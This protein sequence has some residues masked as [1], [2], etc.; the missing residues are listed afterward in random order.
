MHEAGYKI[1]G[2]GEVGGG[3]VNKNGI[4]LK[5]LIEFRQKNGT[6]HG[7]PGAEKCRYRRICSPPSA[8][9]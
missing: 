3:L 6:V 7:F 1:I 8:K 4:D 5:A 9:S 2:I